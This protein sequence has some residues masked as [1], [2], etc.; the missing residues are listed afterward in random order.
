MRLIVALLLLANAL[1]FCWSRGW[2][3]DFSGLPAQSG[4]EPQRL[5]RQIHPE[6]IE[7]LD[8]KAAAALAQIVCLELGPLDGDAALAAAQAALRGANLNLGGQE[9]LT[10]SSEQP[11]VWVVATIKLDNAE[12][13]ARKEATYKSLKIDFEPLAG[14]PSEQPS[15]VL[16]RHASAAE[17]VAEVAALDK[18]GLKGLRV[19]ALQPPRARH[20]LV[21]AQ[22]DGLLGAKLKALKDPALASGFKACSGASSAVAAAAPAASNLPASAA[23]R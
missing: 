5:A 22:A 11:G 12:F 16:S 13:R 14:L 8:G 18:R 15:L 21:M 10:R 23:A 4:R 17:A 9:W 2:L 3:D 6:L 7:L 1:F 19:L 20:S